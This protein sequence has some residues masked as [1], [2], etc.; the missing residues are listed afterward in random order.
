MRTLYLGKWL[1]TA[2]AAGT[3]IEDFAML[4]EG[5]QIL[6]VKKREETDQTEA[7]QVI[8]LKDAY[9]VPGFIDCHVHFLGSTSHGGGDY[10]NENREIANVVCEGAAHAKQLLKAGVVACRDLG[11]YKGYALGIRDAINRGLIVGPK[12]LACGYAV[13]ARGGHGYE[14]S[15]EVDDPD[16][17]RGAVRQVVKDG[18]DVVKLMVSGG[19]NSP[20]PEPGPCELTWEEIQT[21]IE[22]AHNWGRKVGVHAHGN[23]A[24]RRCVD[25]GVDSIEHGVFMTEDIMDKMSAQGTFLV[26]TLCAPYYAVNEG[27]R[28][29]PDN[30]DHKKSKEVL[31]RHRD[32]LKRCWEKGVKIAMGTD[33]GC[34][35]NPY[36][37]AAHEMVLMVMAGLTPKAALDAATRGGAE[38]LDLLELGSLEAGKKA[39]FVCLKGNPLEKIDYVD[40]L[41]ALYMDGKK[42][43]LD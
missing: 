10:A 18:A 41:T 38:L 42:V 5:E 1:Y 32:V 33:A 40:E 23:T 28:L 31:Q 43:N 27:I 25:A 21:G 26:P 22:T 39:S 13:C 6:W 3:V 9:V 30:P 14:I 34:P 37:A 11:S 36:E 12:I 20:G 24:I 15:Y 4:T 16:Q 8:D 2:D 19:V 7:D 35:F 29:E 17:M